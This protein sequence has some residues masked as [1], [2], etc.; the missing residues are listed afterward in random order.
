VLLTATA[1][2]LAVSFLNQP[3]ESPDLRAELADL[4]GSDRP[5]QMLL[6]VGYAATPA[7]PTGRLA[8]ATTS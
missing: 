8:H 4:V 7:L 5:P 6:R 2:G 3:I 1:R